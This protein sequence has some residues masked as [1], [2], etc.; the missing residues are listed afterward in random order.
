MHS[1]RDERSLNLIVSIDF[2]DREIAG[3]GDGARVE[4]KNYRGQLVR[5]RLTCKDKTLN[6]TKLGPMMVVPAFFDGSLV[7]FD[8][9][10]LLAVGEGD[11][12]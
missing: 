3:L 6:S 7:V 8:F 11:P 4:I 10:L 5:R 1:L 9:A 12:D 2:D